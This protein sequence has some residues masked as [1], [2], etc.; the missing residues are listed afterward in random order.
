MREIRTSGAT[1]GERVTGY[2]MRVVSH[3]RGNP[4]TDV[5]RSLNIGYRLSYST[6]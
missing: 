5:Y 3:A 6:G 2:G 4:D 1:R